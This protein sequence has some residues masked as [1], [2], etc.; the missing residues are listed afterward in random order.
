MKKILVV[1][2]TVADIS[3]ELPSLLSSK[4][5]LTNHLELSLGDKIDVSQTQVAV[6][7]SGANAAYGLNKLD[8]S[9]LLY[10]AVGNDMVTDY[11]LEQLRQAG[12]ELFLDRQEKPASFSVI[13]RAKKDRVIFTSHSTRLSALKQPPTSDWLHLG[14]LG[15]KATQLL[16]DALAY[17]VKYDIPLSINPSWDQV[18]ERP[19]ELLTL[20]RSTEVLIVNQKEGAQLA[21][22]STRTLPTD[23]LNDLLHLGPKYVALTCGEKGS[24]AGNSQQLL[25]A[26]PVVN[27]EQVADATGAGDAFTAGF[28]TGLITDSENPLVVA[29][30]AGTANAASAIESVGAWS[31]MLDTDELATWSK[32][33]TVKNAV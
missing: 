4:A 20:L 16:T 25:F 32:K 22:V 8:W 3:F 24:Y 9:A 7:G 26:P 31:G 1:G 11:L 12:L 29:L 28:L 6:G 2:E 33:V 21:K 14:P 5:Q 30:T 10:T 18:N 17:Q 13:L 19:R 15:A 27:R 23:I